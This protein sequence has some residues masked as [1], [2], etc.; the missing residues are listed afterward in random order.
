M[1]PFSTLIV[2]KEKK[3]SDSNNSS[4][5]VEGNVGSFWAPPL[6]SHPPFVFVFVFCFFVFFSVVIVA[7]VIWLFVCFET[8][9]YSL[10]S[11]GWFRLTLP[12][13]PS[14]CWEAECVCISL[15]LFSNIL[16][17]K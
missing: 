4:W 7:L 15:L 17:G 1:E 9:S 3:K 10:C 13:L 11:P 16:C 2:V 8:G 6:P 5:K 12:A 14:K